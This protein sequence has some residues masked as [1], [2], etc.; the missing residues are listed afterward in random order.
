M[1]FWIY[2]QKFFGWPARQPERRELCAG[3]PPILMRQP[4]KCWHNIR[5]IHLVLLYSI[6]LYWKQ[7][8][9]FYCR[10]INTHTTQNIQLLED[11]RSTNSSLENLNGENSKYAYWGT[12]CGFKLCFRNPRAQFSCLVPHLKFSLVFSVKV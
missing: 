8:Y 12:I 10:S 5:Y 3:L 1:T 6:Y 4:P 2:P 7:P 9:D 11:S